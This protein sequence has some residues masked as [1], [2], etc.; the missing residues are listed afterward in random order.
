MHNL[1]QNVNILPSEQ[2]NGKAGHDAEDHS[3]PGKI[4][5]EI[6]KSHICFWLNFSS[7]LAPGI[8]DESDI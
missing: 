7:V 6:Y 2:V 4:A 5:E 1:L 8:D 3:G